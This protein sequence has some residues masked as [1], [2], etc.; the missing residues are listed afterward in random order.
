MTEHPIIFSGPMVRA[1]LDGRK[2][3]TRR[4][5][6]FQPPKSVHIVYNYRDVYI[7]QQDG[8]N[9]SFTHSWNCPY[10]KPGDKLYVRETWAEKSG[11][12][13]P[14]RSNVQYRADDQDLVWQKKWSA[15]IHMPKWAARI[16]L[17][18]IGVRIE[19]VQDI[20][21]DNIWA[22]GIRTERKTPEPKMARHNG[23]TIL[24]DSINAKRGYSWESNPWVWVI[25]FKKHDR[26]KNPS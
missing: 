9:K 16:W 23:F 21:D 5:M 19:R 22:E 10:G 26:K 4:V 2:T 1:I 14:Y 24:W 11:K 8:P 18:I 13:A 12:L 17:D 20:S 3:Q 7:A 25:E 6:K 15:S